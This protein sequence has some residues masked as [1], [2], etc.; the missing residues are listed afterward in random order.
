[1]GSV[2][3]RK[4]LLGLLT[5]I[6]S[7]AILELSLR[8]IYF[9]FLS[10]SSF[11][12]VSA[13]LSAKSY[14]ES[15]GGSKRETNS[16]KPVASEP[17]SVRNPSID[18][19]PGILNELRAIG[20]VVGNAGNPT[21]AKRHDTFLVRPDKMLGYVLRP[22]TLVRGYLLRA[23][24]KWNI[25]P[26]ILYID[27][28]VTPSIQLQNYIKENELI[29]FSYQIDSNGFRKTLPPTLSDRKVLV[30]GDSVAF[31]VG[32][33]DSQTAASQLQSLCRQ[34]LQIVNA[35]VGGYTGKQAIET[36]RKHGSQ[37]RF[38]TLIYVA[39]HNDFMLD[40]DTAYADVL[41]EIFLGFRDVSHLFPKGVAIVLH[42]LMEYNVQ[43]MLAGWSTSVVKQTDEM[44]IRG[45]ET[46]EN[47]GFGYF[48]MT[49]RIRA[50]ARE[51]G[52][53]FEVFSFYVDHAHLS[54]KG[55]AVLAH[56]LLNLLR[57]LGAV[58]ESECDEV[59]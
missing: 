56:E 45:R 39:F 53:I 26:P 44:R 57:E 14:V 51:A 10:Q 19:A 41:D 24:N 43:H 3:R 50:S 7:L 13:V 34:D 4:L 31:G 11:A 48:D 2:A 36:A 49:D 58:G 8:A 35:G 17:E 37:Q 16:L 59:S 30:V 25:D 5:G 28:S 52:S 6:F 42:T 21:N 47:L 1:M 12:T 22:D 54:P 40:A 55:N 9:Q 15:I 32:V 33:D 23:H 18:F 38:D 29:A 46:A 27:G 20:A